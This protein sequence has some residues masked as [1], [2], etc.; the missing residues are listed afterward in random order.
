MPPTKSLKIDL[1][2][3]ASLRVAAYTIPT[4]APEADGTYHWNS[5]TLVAV[6]A[7]AADQ[8]GL[9]YSYADTA[10]AVLINTHLAP[11]VL[12]RDAASPRALWNALYRSVRN[13]GREGIASM[14]ISAVDMAVWDL[15]ARLLGVSILDLLG[16]VRPSIPVYGSGGFTSY[17]VRQLQRQFEEWTAEGIRAVKMKIGASPDAD[18]ARVRA[19]RSAIGDA[20][21]YVDANG[22]YTVKQA[23]DKAHAFADCGV[24]WFEEPVSSDNLDGLRFIRRRAPAQIEIAAGEYGY[25]QAYFRRMI[26]AGAVDVIQADATRCGG[27]TGFLDAAAEADGA[28]IPLSAHTAPSLHGHLCCAATPAR[29]VE[30]F[31]DHVRIERM[32]FDGSLTAQHGNLLPGRSTPGFGLTLKHSAAAA[33]QVYEGGGRP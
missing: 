30:Y 2:P 28:G 5:T 16:T 3:I 27:V 24:T 21:L 17:S 8:T 29:N 12:G 33:F 25:T 10:T 1:A 31:H 20:G 13:L 7:A 23:L 14:A 6:H 32:L 26:A 22:A 19:A 15:K 9:G 4:D 18:L 11:H